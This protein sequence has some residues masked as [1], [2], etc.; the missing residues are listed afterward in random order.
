MEK[1]LW[2]IFCA[3]ASNVRVTGAIDKRVLLIF[4]GNNNGVIVSLSELIEQID[5][6]NSS[7]I[8]ISEYLNSRLALFVMT[9][10]QLLHL[11]HPSIMLIG[12][13]HPETFPLPRFH[14]GI[15]DLARELR[16]RWIGKVTLYDMQ[17]GLTLDKIKNFILSSNPEVIGIS[18]TFGQYDLLVEL[19][20]FLNSP[21]LI[22]RPIIVAGGSLAAHLQADL[23]KSSLLD[24]VAV[25][26]GE[27]A[28]VGIA[29]YLLG[30]LPIEAIPDTA[31]ITNETVVHTNRVSNRND[32]DIMPEL[33]LLDA[34]LASFGVMQLESSRGCS[35]ACSFCPRSH[36]GIWAGEHSSSLMALMP[37]IARIFEKHPL[38][39]KRIFLVDEEFVGYQ[40]DDLALGRCRDVAKVIT[41]FGFNFETSSRIDQVYRP[42][43]SRA[44]H[45]ERMAFWLSLSQNG[46]QRCLFGVESGVDSILTRFNKKTTTAQNVIAVRILSLL[47]IPIRYTYITFDPLMS[48]QE[49]NESLSF[50]ERTD[51][52]LKRPVSIPL[53]DYG[54]ILDIALNDE[55]SARCGVGIPF[56][57]KVSY[58]GV[59]MEAL[60]GSPY[61]KS[62]ES[63][64]LAGATNP[65]MG[66]K[67]SIYIDKR[68]G[69][70]SSVSQ[71]W[72]D[73]SF[74][75]DY[76][77]KSI[78][79]R[80]PS[81]VAESLNDSR[82]LLKS[83][84]HGFIV[85]CLSDVVSSSR[86]MSEAEIRK[87]LNLEFSKMAPSISETVL[88][89]CDQLS[90]V[91]SEIL[92]HQ[93]SLW[94]CPSDWRLI[95]G[96]CD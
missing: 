39:S 70:V 80:V 8:S 87:L 46:M 6:S 19:L 58:L 54:S 32:R 24:F 14:L 62:L 27:G 72:I 20:E 81:H 52:I 83:F 88:A 45:L 28:I 3:V 75:L 63:Q 74:A 90:I 59:S 35:Y 84:C 85:N 68:I 48:M 5:F 76:T 38:I 55:A 96:Q 93:L 77:L 40:T 15:S 23:L 50:L 61:L 17:L 57:H 1:Y 16:A 30:Q 71:R 12:L 13:Y 60:I 91:D 78:Q 21:A 22:K 73:Q 94:K 11:N 49:L 65:L 56:Y 89:I 10:G 67:E 9:D 43:K 36:K 41:S 18:V 42:R 31:Y 26:A 44:W 47:E 53:D 95:N 37:Y 64:G 92:V 82:V 7:N 33:D 79:K 4:T 86:L 2:E 25:G 69:Q 51:L 29:E 66:R 34:T